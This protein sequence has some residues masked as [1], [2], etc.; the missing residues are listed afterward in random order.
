MAERTKKAGLAARGVTLKLKTSD[1]R[2]LTRNRH[3]PYPTRS[4]EE[5]FHAG[6]GLLARE[7][8]GRTFRLIGIGVHDF[9]GSSEATY[10][11]LFDHAE[12]GK[13]ID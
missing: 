12:G 8:D 13:R 7:T 10:G 9:V 3:L 11:D 1:F 4:A 2:I 5:I 6:E